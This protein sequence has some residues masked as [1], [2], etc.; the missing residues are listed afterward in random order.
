MR[1]IG[2]IKDYSRKEMGSKMFRLYT[3][4]N[5][6][7]IPIPKTLLI[8]ASQSR[9]F[10]AD[11]IDTQIE[12]WLSNNIKEVMKV[13][14]KT[15]YNKNLV[16]RSSSTFEDSPFF[17]FAG[18]YESFLKI[19][20]EE[21]VSHAIAL[22]YKSM[23]S[24]N[25][26]SYTAKNNLKAKNNLMAIG[27]QEMKHCELSGVLFTTNPVSND[28]DQ[29]VVE[30]NNGLG[31]KIALGTKIFNEM[32]ISKRE[33]PKSIPPWLKKLV[34]YSL[35]IESL[36]KKPQDIEF[37]YDGN[38]LIIFQSRDIT[39]I[40]RKTISKKKVDGKILYQGSPCS[41][42][43]SVGRLRIIKSEKDF[44]M[45]KKNDIVFLRTSNTVKFTPYLSKI[46]GV[47]IV[48]GKLSHL[49]TLIREY[50][51]PAICVA[52][53]SSP[54]VEKFSSSKVRMQVSENNGT[55]SLCQ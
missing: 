45:I 55:L 1:I 13:V 31:D 49:A 47:I 16:I 40:K 22:I 54:R 15:F 7:N 29:I 33:L 20:G 9:F 6:L 30:W 24:N 37:G 43:E 34:S 41:M 50:N 52:N 5:R 46:S 2:N 27:V 36:Y 26:E 14:N 23:F 28:T 53:A 3:L 44:K 8:P 25:V 51:I 11:S 21:K 19:Q 4:N 17:S 18:Q 38:N 48:G 39:T 35:K 12:K 32:S 42:G 10:S